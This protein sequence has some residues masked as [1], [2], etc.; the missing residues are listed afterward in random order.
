MPECAAAAGKDGRAGMWAMYYPRGTTA[1][2]Q[3]GV[4]PA[5]AAEGSLRLQRPTPSPPPRHLSDGHDEAFF[6]PAAGTLPVNRDVILFIF[7]GSF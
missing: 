2:G 7:Q 6:M 3:A 5:W 4:M 1:Q